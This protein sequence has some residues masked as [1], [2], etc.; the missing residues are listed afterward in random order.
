MAS[1]VVSPIQRAGMMRV[2]DRN[3]RGEQRALTKGERG[4]AIEKTW[5]RWS[6]KPGSGATERTKPRLILGLRCSLDGRP[7]DD[8]EE[9]FRAQL[10]RLAEG[11]AA[12]V[13][14]A[15]L[16][17]EY[18]RNCRLFVQRRSPDIQIGDQI[19][20]FGASW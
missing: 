20:T 18:R 10:P 13:G 12:P 16:C 5:F 4:E 19:R 15:M 8:F 17:H 1:P 6:I 11:K 3:W 14:P 7:E 2:D 9:S